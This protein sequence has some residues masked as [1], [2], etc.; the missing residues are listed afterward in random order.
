MNLARSPVAIAFLTAPPAGLSRIGG[1]LPAGCSY[2]KHASEGHAFYTTAEDHQGCPV[3]AMTHGVVL[4]PEKAQE[5][6]SMVG[7]MIALRYLT[8]EDVAHIPHR[9]DAFRIGAYAPLGRAT[10]VPDIVLFRGNTRQIM[11]LAEAARAAGAFAPGT[12]MGRP[13]CGMLPSALE[14]GQATASIGCIGNRVYTGLGDDELYLTVP[15][16]LLENV[17]ARLSEI[18]T[19]NDVLEAFHRDRAGLPAGASSASADPREH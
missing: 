12:A 9:T 5:L 8:S 14:S 11:L 7:N 17:L 16:P 2:W 15:G 18:L 3:G 10:F 13:A 19:A 1:S 4:P 6:H